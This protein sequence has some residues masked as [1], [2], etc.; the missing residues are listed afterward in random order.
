M[1]RNR[2]LILAC[3]E[4]PGAAA[5]AQAISPE[6]VVIADPAGNALPDPAAPGGDDAT[7]ATAAGL[8]AAN[9]STAG[10]NLQNQS[11]T[12]FVQAFPNDP[13]DDLVNFLCPPVPTGLKFEYFV[14][15]KANA[16]GEASG[17]LNG[18]NGL[19]AVVSPDPA[20]TESGMLVAHGLEFPFS[21]GEADMADATPGWSSEQELQDRLAWL[22]GLVRRG[23]AKRVLAAAATA[24][25]SATS[26]TLGAAVD[27]IQAFETHI[28]TVADE[29]GGREYVRI[30]L[31]STAY[32]I[33]KFHA[34]L[35]G[36]TNYAYMSNGLKRLAD[37]F[38]LPHENVRVSYHQVLTSKQGKTAASGR[39][40][41][42]AQTYVFGA[43][44]RP[45]KRDRSFMKRFFMNT[46]GAPMWVYDYE[47][48][49]MQ[50]RRGLAYYE[51]V[52]ATNTSAVKRL[53]LAT[54]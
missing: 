14:R 46:N 35:A 33:L 48:H 13:M 22:N 29:M 26:L 41:T 25:G 20:S 5:P 18:V 1:K 28:Q 45:N 37:L 52:K 16:M 32:S 53:T 3:N 27:P 34:K 51:L 40:L 21:Q 54:S 42:A 15:G 8:L 36:G 38:E 7:P 6:D 47:P 24:A 30:L 31:G 19:P 2:T 17:D 43:H 50:Q 10:A 39:I 11:L 23:I 4:E 44:S 12:S 49:P 9:A